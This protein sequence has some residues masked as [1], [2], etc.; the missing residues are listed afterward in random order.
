MVSTPRV[1]CEKVRKCAETSNRRWKGFVKKDVNFHSPFSLKIV[2]YELH[3]IQ[4]LAYHN[5][6]LAADSQEHCQN[7]FFLKQHYTKFVLL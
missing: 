4:E 5:T 3:T 2:A 7:N 1:F 6:H